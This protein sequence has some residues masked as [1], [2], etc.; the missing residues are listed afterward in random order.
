MDSTHV[1]VL[2]PVHRRKMQQESGARSVSLK[3]VK[4]Q[5]DS[6]QQQ[7]PLPCARPLDDGSGRRREGLTAAH[8]SCC[9]L[10]L[11]RRRPQERVVRDEALSSRVEVV[12]IPFFSVSFAFGIRL[13]ARSNDTGPPR[14]LLASTVHGALADFPGLYTCTVY[15]VLRLFNFAHK[16]LQGRARGY[17]CTRVHL[18]SSSLRA[19]GRNYEIM[20][21]YP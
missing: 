1:H 8:P 10:V 17:T 19:R 13:R 15:L 11:L 14:K 9:V 2:A 4:T 16:N 7:R 6:W 5:L 12:E 20:R 18:Y 3:P 21:S